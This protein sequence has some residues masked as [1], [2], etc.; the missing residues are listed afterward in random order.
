[1]KQTKRKIG[2]DY[3]KLFCFHPNIGN[4]LNQVVNN[5]CHTV[6]ITVSLSLLV[7]KL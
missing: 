3:L 5:Y 1:M 2:A 7:V 4:I 6:P